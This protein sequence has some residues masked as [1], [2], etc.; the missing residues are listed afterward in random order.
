MLVLPDIDHDREFSAEATHRNHV[1][2]IVPVHIRHWTFEFDLEIL[3]GH[4]LPHC[5]IPHAG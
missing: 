1:L 5:N 3:N 4:H 2:P